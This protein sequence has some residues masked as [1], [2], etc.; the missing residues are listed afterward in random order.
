VSL[1]ESLGTD[2]VKKLGG[3]S[4]QL[5]KWKSALYALEVA[6]TYTSTIEARLRRSPLS[7][8]LVVACRLHS[9]HASQGE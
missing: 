3:A 6:C 1:Q 4:V 2:Q 9:L 7:A 5:S 8:A